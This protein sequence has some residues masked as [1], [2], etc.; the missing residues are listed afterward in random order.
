MRRKKDAKN[1]WKKRRKKIIKLKKEGELRGK[2]NE[3]FV[4]GL[5]VHLL[6]NKKI[7]KYRR[8]EKND[9]LDSHQKDFIFLISGDVFRDSKKHSC[10]LDVKSNE[11][12][13]YFKQK[14]HY[15]KKEDD[16]IL[17]FVPKRL[18][19]IEEEAERLLKE[20]VLHSKKVQKILFQKKRKKEFFRLLEYVNGR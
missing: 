2:C 14:K 7:I 5:L 20:A 12:F 16:L 9:D 4:E 1:Y 18:K 10:Y 15:P 17:R 19:P 13:R 3:D 6:E 11:H 8:S